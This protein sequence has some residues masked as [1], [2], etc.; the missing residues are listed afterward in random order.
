MGMPCEVNSILKLSRE[1]GFPETLEYGVVYEAVKDDYR[2]LLVDVPVMLV[3][4]N[5]LG[6]ADVV[7]QRLTWE[8]GKTYVRFTVSRIYSTPFVAKEE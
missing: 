7:I 5:W 8:G 4:S 3:D 1:N 2:I 6:Q